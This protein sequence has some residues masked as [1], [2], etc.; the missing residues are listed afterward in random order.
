MSLAASI[1]L[2]ALIPAAITLA[3]LHAWL[4][5]GKAMP[6]DVANERSL[7]SGAIPR[8]GG[9]AMDAGVGVGLA[10]LPH[11]TLPLWLLV[12][13]AGLFLLSALDDW[14]SLPVFP[15]LSGHLAAAGI[16]ALSFQLPL[17]LA[18]FAM[19]WLAW[20]T[21]LYNF[22]DGADGLAGMMAVIGFGAFAL[23]AWPNAP[24][25]SIACLSIASASAGFIRYNFPPARVFLGDA[26]SIPL[27]FLAGA[28]GLTGVQDD[29]WPLWFPLMVFSPFIAD[30]TTT[31][32]RRLIQGKK[33]WRAH[34]EHYYQ[35]LILMNW[36]HRKLVLSA[37]GLMVVAAGCAMALL[38][39]DAYLQWAGC[40][41]MVVI[42]L[43]SFRAIEKRW[44]QATQQD[45]SIVEARNQG[46]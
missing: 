5:Q 23:A 8:I 41:V 14:Y 24:E 20:M 9:I 27:G 33:V 30:G 40:A 13:A 28:V 38:R 32:L 25:I 34:R 22:M 37:A 35:R 29:I 43:F 26:G 11:A 6:L 21:N 15:R 7:H 2:A 1:A 44:Q 10:I 16:V 42:Y 36:S 12:G 31:L 39:F 18:V 45:P 46:A 19:L 17:L 3:I 4:R